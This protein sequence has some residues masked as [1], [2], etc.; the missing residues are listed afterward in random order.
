[1]LNSC[2]LAHY[3][4]ITKTLEVVVAFNKSFLSFLASSMGEVYTLLTCF[5]LFVSLCI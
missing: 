2:L 4:I 3:E 1:M 5:G